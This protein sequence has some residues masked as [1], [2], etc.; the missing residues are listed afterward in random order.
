VNRTAQLLLI[1]REAGL[2]WSPAAEQVNTSINLL[3]KP[4]DPKLIWATRD[5]TLGE[6]I[7][8][9][10][11]PADHSTATT[12]FKELLGEELQLINDTMVADNL[13]YRWIH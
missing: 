6:T 7:I 9:R 13:N 10:Y 12:V 5:Y 2:Y 8:T 11:N 4:G 1:D 3:S